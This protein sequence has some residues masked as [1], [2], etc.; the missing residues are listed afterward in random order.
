MPGSITDR[1][2][3]SRGGRPYWPT[4]I[5][6]IG[7][8]RTRAEASSTLINAPREITSAWSTNTC[9][10]SAPVAPGNMSCVLICSTLGPVPRIDASNAPK[11]RSCVNSNRP[12]LSRP[13][14]N[15]WIVVRRL[16]D[17]RPV[18]CI[19]PGT[20]RASTQSGERFISTRIFM[21]WTAVLLFLH[22]AKRRM[23][24]LLECHPVRDT[25]MLSGF[26]RGSDGRQADLRSC[27][28]DAHTAD[29]G[30]AAHYGRIMCDSV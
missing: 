16:S 4:A 7:K 10:T 22:S 30:L 20:F 27:H 11:S 5:H 21:E 25:D 15:C 28:R 1:S 18:N 17:R 13:V 14:K 26:L 29:A 3:L 23:L 24:A 8:I 6:S 12:L 19:V 2:R 9:K